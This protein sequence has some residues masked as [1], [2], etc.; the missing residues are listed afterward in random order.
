MR[1]LSSEEQPWLPFLA[2][3]KSSSGS[4]STGVTEFL[5]EK[6]NKNEGDRGRGY[7]TI[8]DDV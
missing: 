4:S 1:S 7:G 6:D 5:R 8:N 3:C 2:S